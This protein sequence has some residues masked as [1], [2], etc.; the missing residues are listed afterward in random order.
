MS[1]SCRQ[2][3]FHGA[4]QEPLEFPA[5]FA[6]DQLGEASGGVFVLSP[7]TPVVA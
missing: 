4:V 1:L 3:V 2:A 6:H 5:R 7:P